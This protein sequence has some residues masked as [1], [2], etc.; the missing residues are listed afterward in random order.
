MDEIKKTRLA[1]DNGTVQLSKRGTCFQYKLIRKE[2]GRPYERVA[3]HKR[4]Q[5]LL[6]YWELKRGTEIDFV[7]QRKGNLKKFCL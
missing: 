3:C 2:G 4:L 1:Y 6:F 5:Y 7:I